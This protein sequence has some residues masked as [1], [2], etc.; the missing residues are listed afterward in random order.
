M[1]GKERVCLCVNLVRPMVW[2]PQAS[3]FPGV[4][5]ESTRRAASVGPVTGSDPPSLAP[6]GLNLGIGPWRH[7]LGAPTRI[8]DSLAGS[9]TGSLLT[10]TV[11]LSGVRI[12]A[13]LLT[14]R[15]S[16]AVSCSLTFQ[17]SGVPGSLLCPQS[18]LGPSPHSTSAQ[19]ISCAEVSQDTDGRCGSARAARG[20]PGRKRPRRRASWFDPEG[21]LPAEGVCVLPSSTSQ[22]TTGRNLVVAHFTGKQTG[23]SIERSGVALNPHHLDFFLSKECA[24]RYRCPCC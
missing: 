21:R 13:R 5:A 9:V 12:S 14:R 3:V 19:R 15:E 4:L 1:S 7:L 11:L 20:E 10:V 24:Q 16:C 8:L 6:C 18:V 2:I 23:S 22:D 17:N